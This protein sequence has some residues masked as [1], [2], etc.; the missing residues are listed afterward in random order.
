MKKAYKHSWL[1]QATMLFKNME[2]ERVCYKWIF[3]PSLFISVH[4]L[5]YL[6]YI[7]K[8]EK[9]KNHMKQ[10]VSSALERPVSLF[11]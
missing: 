1:P 10:S 2:R 6:L 9:N 3:S 4:V 11:V 8:L 5:F 7:S